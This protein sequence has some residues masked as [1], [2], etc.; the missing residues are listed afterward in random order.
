MTARTGLLLVDTDMLI[1]L[2][3]TDLLERIVASLGYTITQVRRLS[4]APHQVRK[5]KRFRDTYGEDVLQSV[6]PIIS[7]IKEADPPSD[8]DLLDALNNLVD[9]G[10]AQLMAIAAH[11]RC[12]LLVSGDKRAIVSLAESNV[13][14][15]IESLQGKIVSLEA[16]LWALLSEQPAEEVRNAFAPVL[17]HATLR[18]VLSQ[19]A[20]A[21]HDRC[22]SGVMN[23]YNALHRQSKGVLYNPD[24]DRL[25]RLE[26]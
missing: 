7:A 5:S 20:A 26:S 16:V 14:S 10:E 15:C 3:A 1:L 4:A 18:I 19:H 13:T 22:L 8:L 9:E 17:N 25:G 21:D 23:Y 24:P 12:T 2:A 11:Q 6:G